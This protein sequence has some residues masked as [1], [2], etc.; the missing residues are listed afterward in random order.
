[1]LKKLYYTT[2]KFGYYYGK[3]IIGILG[4]TLFL[5]SGLKEANDSSGF[6]GTT[7]IELKTTDE[8]RMLSEELRIGLNEIQVS[9]VFQNVTDHP[10]K[11]IV[12]FPL[13]SL[14][15]SAGL[16][17]PNWN[18]PT[19]NQDFLNFKV[20]V[21]DKSIKP[22]LERRAFFQGKEVTR[23]LETTGAIALVPWKPGGYDEQAK[24]LSPQML[25]RLRNSGLITEGEDHNTP[26]WQLHTKYFWNQTFPPKTNVKVKHIYKPFVDTALIDKATQING[27][28]VVG[29][30]IGN[31]PTDKDRYCLDEATKRALVSEEKK[32]PN[33]MVFSVAE[34]EYILTTARNWRGPIGKFHLIIDKGSPKNIIS[35]CWN[36][37]KKTG[38]TTFE[39]VITNFVPGEDIRLLIFVHH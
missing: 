19:D 33:S 24:L 27:R 22:T 38:A 8:I 21:N 31:H 11:T 35:L 7:G 37:L 34:I 14:D 39:S 26:Q 36:G 30:F 20:W 1:M 16:T 4:I 23:E 17:G 12:V 5:T 6:Q 13:P 25:K 15:L 18:F 28:S 2:R 32:N 29:R 3:I 10:V 9:Y